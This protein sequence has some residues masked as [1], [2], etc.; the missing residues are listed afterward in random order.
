MSKTHHV[1]YAIIKKDDGSYYVGQHISN[2][3]N[4]LG[5]YWGSGKKLNEA[6][7][8]Y[9]K[10]AFVKV[11]LAEVDTPEQLQDLERR[12]VNKDMINDPK[13]YNDHVGGNSPIKGIKHRDVSWYKSE[14][15]RAHLKRMNEM[16]LQPDAKRRQALATKQTELLY[17]EVKQKRVNSLKQTTSSPEYKERRSKEVKEWYKTEAGKKVRDQK[18]Q[19]HADNRELSLK[20]IAHAKSCVTEEGKQRSAAA[21]K[22]YTRTHRDEIDAR[23]RAFYQTERGKEHLKNLVKLSSSPESRKK[24]SE[25]HKEY[26]KTE[27]G[28]AHLAKAHAASNTEQALEKRRMTFKKNEE[29]HPERSIKRSELHK[30]IAKRPG[31][32]ERMSDAAKRVYESERGDEIKRKISESLKRYYADKKLRTSDTSN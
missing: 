9:G 8:K 24:S 4:P 20:N 21:L 18:K 17:P 2:T 5:G 29:L 22:E 11:V 3:A 30:E 12:V 15:G 10:D 23:T 27:Q 31:Q 1:L 26:F 19:W 25:S 6:Y 14:E 13:C 32:R 28:K 7:K 16:S